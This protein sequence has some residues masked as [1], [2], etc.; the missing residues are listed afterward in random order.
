MQK[1]ISKQKPKLPPFK[2]IR[3][4]NAIRDGLMKAAQKMIPP[5]VAL[6]DLVSR[7]WVAQAV[8]TVARY[9]I[10]DHINGPTSVEQLAKK[11]DVNADALYRV[12]RALTVVGVCV[13]HPDQ[14]FSLT[15]IGNCL[16]T[17]HPQSMRHMVIFQTELNWPHWG[18]IDHCLKT[19]TNAVEKVRGLKP[20]E[21][22]SKNPR[23]A[24]IFDKAMVNVSGLEVDT[25]LA[26]YD[27]GPY[28]TIADIGGG[29]GPF[30]SAVL[31]LNPK[32]KGILFDMPHVIKGASEFLKKENLSDRV[33]IEGGSFFDS[34]PEGA[35]AYM[36]KHIIHDWSDE[37]SQKIL[38]NIRAKMKSTAKLLLI[39]A[40][41]PGPNEVDFSKFLDLEM[42]VVTE[43][44]KERTKAEF[45]KLFASAGFQLERIVPTI[46]MAQ[47]IEARPV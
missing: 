44:G 12:L 8:G 16:K 37:H 2:I 5:P 38:K 21:Y 20:F 42:L 13:E 4:V 27:F 35:D 23:D 46:S 31:H 25:I 43:G 17:D 24:E 22:L 36:M 28:Q 41:V 33:R 18:Q 9:G 39:E 11:V 32:A 10:A 1:Q 14:R 30:L 47:V 19:G 34:I 26:A 15:A 45:E 7:I 3:G 6:L 29:Y 40:V